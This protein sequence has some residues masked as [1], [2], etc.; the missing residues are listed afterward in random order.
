MFILVLR[1]VRIMCAYNYFCKLQDEISIISLIDIN[2]K[3]LSCI[4][5]KCCSKL[6]NCMYTRPHIPASICVCMI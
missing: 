1:G 3:R 2:S 6:Y 5:D 4:Y